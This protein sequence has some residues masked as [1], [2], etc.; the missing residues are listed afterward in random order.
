MTSQGKDLIR[1]GLVLTIVEGLM[2]LFLVPFY[3]P[4]I[5]LQWGEIRHFE[6]GRARLHA[7]GYSRRTPYLT[8]IA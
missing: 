6:E 5:G 7:P 8:N 4:L 2:L 1:V 3:W